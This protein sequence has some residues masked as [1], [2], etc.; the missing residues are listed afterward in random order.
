MGRLRRGYATNV[1]RFGLH[2]LDLF[3]P[4]RGHIKILFDHDKN[5]ECGEMKETKLQ[6]QNGAEQSRMREVAEKTAVSEVV[7]C[8]YNAR[9]PF[10]KASQM[11]RA[12][13]KNGLQPIKAFPT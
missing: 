10:G 3:I 4:G 6:L 12:S 7:V 8:Y 5:E 13:N 2:P 9:R 1:E 11:R